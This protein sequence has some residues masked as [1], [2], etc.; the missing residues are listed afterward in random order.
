MYVSLSHW[1]Q[2]RA[3]INAPEPYNVVGNDKKELLY[4]FFENRFKNKVI[5]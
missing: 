2:Q 5:I 4:Q 1:S 3:F